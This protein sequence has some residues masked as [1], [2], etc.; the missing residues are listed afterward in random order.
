[1]SVVLAVPIG[2]EVSYNGIAFDG[3]S[4]ISIQ[5]DFIKDEAERT[6]LYH[7]HTIRVQAVVQN[8]ADTN[9]D[10]E[11]IRAQLGEHG[12]ELIVQGRGFGNDLLVNT[13][14]G[15]RDVRFGPKPTVLQWSPLASNRAG[16]IEWQCVACVAVCE[17]EGPTRF[18]GLM[19]LNYDVTFAIDDKGY[20]TRTI[21]GHLVVAQTRVGKSIPDSADNYL[22]A[23]SSVVPLGYKR[24]ISR[25]LSLDKSRLDFT[26]TDTQIPSPNAYPPGVVD[27]EAR[28]SAGRRRGSGF[29]RNTLTAEIELAPGVAPSQSLVIFAAIAKQRID[30]TKAAATKMVTT[31]ITGATTTT[32]KSQQ[33]VL[34][35]DFRLEEGI[36]SRRT[37]FSATW[38]VPQSLQQ[39][40]PE[41]GIWL[42]LPTNWTDWHNSIATQQSVTGTAGMRHLPTDDRIID[43]CDSANIS[44]QS[45][46][47][48]YMVA[49]LAPYPGAINEQ[50]LPEYSWLQYQNRVLPERRRPVMIQRI[51]QSPDTEFA[52]F[53]PNQ[54]A[55]GVEYPSASG[56]DDI[57]QQGGK[58]TYYCTLVG[59]AVR[60]GHQIPRPKYGQIGA[61]TAT[62]IG[63]DFECVLITNLFG[64]PVYAA[65]WRIEYALPHS[66]GVV[67]LVPNPMAFMNGDGSVH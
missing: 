64:L 5:V 65:K 38:L 48:S 39:L 30:A 12:R 49:G 27:I 52:S 47:D 6:V 1:M 11:T 42:P 54:T 50:P 24:T 16:E 3:A 53:V 33:A 31:S 8:N 7:Q 67:N 20:T 56:L 57:I 28:H 2:T 58:S 55:Q 13:A 25:H 41:C 22:S 36:F 37:T 9:G 51:V 43:L 61:A 44:V 32:T 63:G 17:G 62:E 66:P 40:L 10:M 59:H 19:S 45:G 23:M 4:K 26:V 35:E 15:V 60:A 29:V 46:Q 21:S 18:T 34:L 14:G